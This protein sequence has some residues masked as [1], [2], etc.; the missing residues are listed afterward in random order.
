[1]SAKQNHQKGGI[2][3]DHI[4][5]RVIG[6]LCQAGKLSDKFLCD[7]NC[8][9]RSV[10]KKEIKSG[11]VSVNG[12]V[13]RQSEFQIDETKDQIRYRGSLCRY[14]KLPDEICLP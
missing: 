9:T 7:M 11:V 1:M 8:G 14:E 12:T 10:L 5:A 6:E 4:A 3:K 13:I 2:E